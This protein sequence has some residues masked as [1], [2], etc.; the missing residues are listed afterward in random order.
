LLPYSLY[1]DFGASFTKVAGVDES[2]AIIFEFRV[3]APKLKSD[4]DSGFRA[5]SPKEY[6]DH[7][8]LVYRKAV[9]EFGTPMSIAISGQVACYVLQNSNDEVVLGV[10][11]WQDDSS[12]HRSFSIE[13][14][15][16]VEHMPHF[17]DG[18][19][20]GLPLLSM[21]SNLRRSLE[22]VKEEIFYI[23]LTNF[24]LAKIID[25]KSIEI[26]IHISEAHASG[27]YS[28]Q[29]DEWLTSALP[30]DIK[31]NIRFPKVLK[32]PGSLTKSGSKTNYWV[33]I[34]DQQAAVHGTAIEKDEYLIHIATGGQVLCKVDVFPSNYANEFQIRPDLEDE[35]YL[36]TI[37]H[38]PAGRLFNRLFHKLSAE[39]KESVDWSYLDSLSTDFTRHTDFVIDVK[40][41]N[42]GLSEFP[43]FSLFEDSLPKYLLTFVDSV[44]NVY[45][46]ALDQLPK[47]QGNRFVLSGGLLTS[48]QLMKELFQSKLPSHSQFRCEASDTSLLG[49]RKMVQNPR[50]LK[51]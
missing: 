31:E 5:Y 10:V 28:I 44:V 48:S 42:S 29:N 16:V 23:N 45:L 38:L 13:V 6:A 11:S 24:L 15:S 9:E 1:L 19:R 2:N 51:P 22:S 14:D 12:S 30:V 40:S 36:A 26:P 47:I 20:P 33:P 46:D 3:P 7:A 34:G 50:R 4:F 17:E 18:L 41:I 21:I 37:T 8:L 49:L 27:M 32:K 43:Q 39:S 35:G 25:I